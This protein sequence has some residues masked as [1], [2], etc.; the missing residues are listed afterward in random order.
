MAVIRKKQEMSKIEPIDNT[1]DGGYTHL[2]NFRCLHCRQH[3]IL[4]FHGMGVYKCKCGKDFYIR[5][6]R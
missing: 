1:I 6:E 2:L 4:H 5:R 3:N